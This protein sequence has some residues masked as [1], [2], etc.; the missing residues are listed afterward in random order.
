MHHH[1]EGNYDIFPDFCKFVKYAR[2]KKNK[3][4]MELYHFQN[5]KKCCFN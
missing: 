2:S 3:N 4:L 5:C 1:E